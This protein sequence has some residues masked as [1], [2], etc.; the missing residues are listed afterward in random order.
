M[1]RGFREGRGH[2]PAKLVFCETD[3]ARYRQ[4]RGALGARAVELRAGAAAPRRAGGPVLHVE[5]D[6]PTPAEPGSVR[7]TLYVAE[8]RQAVAPRQ[9][10]PLPW[11]TWELLRRRV[12]RFDESVRVGRTMWRELLS[13]E[14]R[15]R[16]G[17]PGDH[18]LVVLGDE[19]ASG[20]P[21]ELLMEDRDGAPP[22]AGGIVRRIALR[23]PYRPPAEQVE[24]SRL[25]AL[26]VANPCGDL[27]SA[28]PETDEVERALSGRAD[29]IVER[30]DGAR[31]TISAVTEALEQGI[32]DLFHYAGHAHLD[33]HDPEQSGLLL[34]DGTLTAARLPAAALQLVF[35][36]ACES[37]RL[38]DVEPG[39]A[40]PRVRG[41]G[42]SLAEAFLRAG[43]RAFVG[44]FYAVDDADARRFASIVHARLAA[45][46]PLGGAIRAARD[47]LY[48]AR[49][50]DWGNFL[51][52][53]DDAL[54]L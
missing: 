51:L 31:A 5:V 24:R 27:P 25:R 11:E 46:S 4:L 12:T 33:E 40:A 6:E 49:S 26:L 35:L 7:C 2:L 30:M 14:I 47:A 1:I 44:T 19:A 32:Y 15:D 22:L 9:E 16:L 8:D 10:A 28:G 48:E 39:R 45:G 53:G 17:Q 21:W 41:N 43:V 54:V 37:G 23:G 29:V 20:L 34:A 36:S 50:P 42:R 18:R 52:F 3:R 38:R 13:P